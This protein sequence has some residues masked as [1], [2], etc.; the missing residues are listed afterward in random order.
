M[1]KF[2]P[3]KIFLNSWDYSYPPYQ[4]NKSN[5]IKGR[6][7]IKMILSHIIQSSYPDTLN[8]PLSQPTL[9]SPVVRRFSGLQNTLKDPHFI[10]MSEAFIEVSSKAY[11]I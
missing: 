9:M 3:G 4:P 1:K 8:K 11:K 6:T 5:M 2:F 10:S 7:G